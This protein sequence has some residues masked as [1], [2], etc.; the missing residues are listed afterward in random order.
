MKDSPDQIIFS[1]NR[2][3]DTL[4][5]T[6]DPFEK[7]SQTFDLFT[8]DI[9]RKNNILVRLSEGKYTDRLQPSSVAKNQ[10]TYIGNQNGIF[11]RYNAKFDSSISF[12][13][14]IAHYRYYI[15]S[16]PFTNYDRNIRNQSVINGTDPFR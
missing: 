8:Y 2:L 4:T 6:A 13:D 1:S 16:Q 5:N 10:F 11:N 9:T 7:V 14:T 3:S 15:N 12:I